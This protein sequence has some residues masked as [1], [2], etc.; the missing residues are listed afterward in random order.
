MLIASPYLAK[1][2]QI[3]MRKNE[4]ASSDAATLSF[5][6]N[7]ICIRQHLSQKRT[8]FPFLNFASGKSSPTENNYGFRDFRTQPYIQSE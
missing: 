4:P 8:K 5:Y 2:K 7:N 3:T 1:P 6:D